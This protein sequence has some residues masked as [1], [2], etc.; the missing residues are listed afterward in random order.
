MSR[1]LPTP[2]EVACSFAIVDFLKGEGHS[3]SDLQLSDRPDVRLSIDGNPA[4]Y[5]CVQIPPRRVFEYSKTRFK[6]ISPQRGEARSIQVVWPKE[7]HIWVSEAIAEKQRDFRTYRRNFPEGEINL[8]IHSPIEKSSSSINPS[9]AGVMNQIRWA[10]ARARTK[11]NA[12]F[13]FDPDTGVE[14]IR[15]PSRAFV[16]PVYDFS[17]GYPTSS[18]TMTS[19][20][21]FTTTKEGDSPVNYDFGAA[22]LEVLIVPPVD[23]Q[24]RK[25]PP[26][27]VSKR[28]RYTAETG[29]TTAQVKRHQI[30]SSDTSV[31]PVKVVQ[32]RIK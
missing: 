12:I 4:A 30:E 9:D 31:S 18:F 29:S 23:A 22:H 24:F 25:Y 5:E 32:S 16:E 3:V 8:L 10:A 1:K 19:C 28:Y 15:P 2:A 11:F 20:G 17:R 7:A 26:Y 27:Y 13:F 6:Q 14:R 21:P